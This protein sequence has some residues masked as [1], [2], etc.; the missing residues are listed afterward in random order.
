MTK[1]LATQEEFNE[2]VLKYETFIHSLM[3]SYDYFYLY[4]KIRG[5]LEGYLAA[6]NYNLTTEQEEQLITIREEIIGKD[7]EF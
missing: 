1:K 4:D 2:L 6:L 5:Y 7:D 3:E